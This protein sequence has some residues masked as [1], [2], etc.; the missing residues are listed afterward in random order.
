MAKATQA[1]DVPAH[2]IHAD[3]TTRE[4]RDRFRRGQAR[5]E[6]EFECLLLSQ[7]GAGIDEFFLDRLGHQAR[8]I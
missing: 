5:H 6:D 3:A 8:G 4:I 7:L 1:L 2:H